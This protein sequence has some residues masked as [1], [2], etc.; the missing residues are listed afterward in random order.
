MAKIGGQLGQT[1]ESRAK[2]IKEIKDWFNK[3][4]KKGPV[5]TSQIEAAFPERSKVLIYKALGEANVKKLTRA[6]PLQTKFT[7]DITKIINDV[8]SN[9]APLINASPQKIFAKL[10]VI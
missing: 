10:Y 4:I 9:K 7:K 2:N 1:K 6:T 5:S 8:S 3:A